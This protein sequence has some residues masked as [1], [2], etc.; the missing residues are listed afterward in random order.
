[1]QDA[2]YKKSIWLERIRDKTI[3]DDGAKRAFSFLKDEKN[4][5]PLTKQLTK[6]PSLQLILTIRKK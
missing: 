1:V 2:L 5:L 3:T 4:A 6:Q